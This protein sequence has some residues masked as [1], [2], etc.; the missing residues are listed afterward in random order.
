MNSSERLVNMEK[1]DGILK[2]VNQLRVSLATQGDPGADGALVQVWD[3][4]R[5][6]QRRLCN[7]DVLE[8][9][10]LEA[11]RLDALQQVKRVSELA[12]EWGVAPTDR[13]LKCGGYAC[14]LAAE[15]IKKYQRMLNY[16]AQ[17]EVL[18]G[19]AATEGV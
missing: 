11:L 10:R 15:K 19:G 18:S 14:E 1:L 17:M 16:S 13:A 12:I 7:Q 3:V 2:S 5:D 6:L 4:T 8:A 9:L